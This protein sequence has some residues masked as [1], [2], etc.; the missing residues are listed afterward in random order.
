VRRGALGLYI[1]HDAHCTYSE[2][3]D[4]ND[5]T[6]NM[7]KKSHDLSPVCDDVI[8]SGTCGTVLICYG[9]FTKSA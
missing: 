8:K 3:Y 6:K 9:T 4:T 2:S 5:D 7:R 1:Y